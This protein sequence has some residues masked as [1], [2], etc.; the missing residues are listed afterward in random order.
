MQY[1]YRVFVGSRHFG[2]R[3]PEKLGAGGFLLHKVVAD[4]WPGSWQTHAS[5]KTT[6]VFISSHAVS[7]TSLCRSMAAQAC[8]WSPAVR[9]LY[10]H[11]STPS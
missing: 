9:L 11:N 10:S 7:V 6:L 2:L 3:F 8:H 5:R 1:R 4:A